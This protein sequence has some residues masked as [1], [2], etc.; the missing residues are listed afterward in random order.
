MSSLPR[1]LSKDL[2]Q[3]KD[4]EIIKTKQTIEIVYENRRNKKK[5]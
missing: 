2:S 1:N 5:N 3:D 4:V